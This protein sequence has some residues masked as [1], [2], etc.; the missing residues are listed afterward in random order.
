[1]S[2]VRVA[3]LLK[4]FPRL[5]ETFVL[6]E[7]LQQERL[8]TFVHVFSRRAPDNEPRHPEFARLVAQVEQLKADDRM[9]PW[10]ALFG[11]DPESH[12]L[13]ERF[14]QLVRE[15]SQYRHERMPSLFAEA[16]TVLRRAK[17]ERIEHIHAHFATDSALVAMLVHDLGGPGYSVTAHAKDIYRS[18]VNPKLLSRLIAHSRFTVTV[19]DANVAHLK[20]ILEPA[21]MAKVRRLYN[22]IDLTAFAPRPVQRDANHVLC[23]AR[24][25][26]KKGF[27]TLVRA[28]KILV[29]RG[30]EVKATFV[31]DGEDRAL[32]EAE[33]ARCGMG[34]RIVLT[35]ALD[36]EKVRGLLAQ[37]TLMA[38]P[39][40]I[41]EDGNRDALP[42]TLIESLAMGLPCISTPVVGIPEILDQGRAGVMV[43][44]N[45]DQATA[46][47]IGALLADPARR[48]ELAK[49]G[50]AR[51]ER[52]FDGRQSAQTLQDWFHQTSRGVMA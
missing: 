22:G 51:A 23:V 28:M 36:Q 17:E 13:L 9:E 49:L 47:A 48:A 20:S 25:V 18:T 40:V 2:T 12:T 10:L 35:G 38:L 34:S 11:P 45:D 1:M 3:Y 37:A 21:A 6:N 8:S 50:R 4:K 31:G 24:L 19:C 42:T 16:L 27:P 33:I 44:E 43:P 41:G 30:I 5:S 26:E 39:C 29:D 14:G 32:I 7:I 46:D 52:L 15:L